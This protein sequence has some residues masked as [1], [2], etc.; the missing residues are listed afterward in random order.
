MLSRFAKRIVAALSSGPA[1]A[2]GGGPRLRSSGQVVGRC[3]R[4]KRQGV[5]RLAAGGAAGRRAAVCT[6]LWAGLWAGPAAADCGGGRDLLAELAE[7]DPHAHAE[8]LAEAAAEPNAEGV[9]WTV[10][11]PGAPTSWLMGSYHIPHP[12]ID[13]A[14]PGVAAALDA[15]RVMLMEMS[16]EDMGGMATMI[17]ENPT[18]VAN[19][20]RPPLDQALAPD[21]FEA[22]AAALAPLGVP[23][24]GVAAMRPWILHLMLATPPCAMA[25]LAGGGGAMDLRLAERAAR[26]GLQVKGMETWDTL[27][28]VLQKDEWSAESLDALVLSAREADEGRDMQTTSARL[29]AEE[30]VWPIWTFGIWRAERAGRDIGAEEVRELLFDERNRRFVAAALPELERGGAFVLAG[31]LHLGGDQGMV[32]L[33]RGHGFTVERASLR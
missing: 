21:D 3:S 4:R 18:L 17:A 32:R 7:S 27:L 19:L 14:P 20:D 9:F 11:K 12:L 23:R 25:D 29:Y 15:A 1:P 13:P 5:G 8:I 10:S 30:R 24:E 31:A 6:A 28:P 16:P 26:R 2:P 33:L 22:L